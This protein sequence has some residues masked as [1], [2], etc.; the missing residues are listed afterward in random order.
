MSNANIMSGHLD[1][2]LLRTF[3][4]IADHGSFSRA[5][6]VVGRSQSAVSLQMKRLEDTAGCSLFQ[7]R[8]HGVSLTASGERLLRHARSILRLME[9]AAGELN[10]KAVAGTVRLGMPTSYSTSLLSAV[11]TRFAAACPDVEVTVTC[12]LSLPLQRAFAAGEF[13]LIVFAADR[14][15]ADG[16]P[17]VHDPAVWVTSAAHDTHLCDPLPVALFEPGCWWRD[18]ALQIVEEHGR[19]WRIACTS[20]NSEPLAAA[21]VSGLAVAVLELSAVPEGARILT[22]AEGF[23]GFPGSTVMLRRH[24]GATTRAVDRMEEVIRDV[25][26]RK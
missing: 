9:R 23:P 12:A 8:S 17:L 26:C 3:V 18:R 20:Q 15:G 10:G 4:A 24:P 22:E 11:L 21:V 5:G 25:F 7:R 19:R 2:D 14:A 16:E 1:S 6:A 13:D